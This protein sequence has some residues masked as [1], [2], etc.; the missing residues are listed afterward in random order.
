ML[1][2]FLMVFEETKVNIQKNH[3][4]SHL[5]VHITVLNALHQPWKSDVSILWR[6][7]LLWSYFMLYFK[8]N[9]NVEKK[10]GYSPKATQLN[11]KIGKGFKNTGSYFIFL[12]SSPIE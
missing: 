10:S 9:Q 12:L 3:L 4:L 1:S 8:H 5:Q 2:L 7:S 6:N 11:D